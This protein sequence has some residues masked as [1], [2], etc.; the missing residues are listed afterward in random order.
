MLK[1]KK[2]AGEKA[3]EG[4]NVKEGEERG[5]QTEPLPPDISRS[6][7]VQSSIQKML[8]E[9]ERV[10]E[11][12]Q[13]REEDVPKRTNT[14]ASFGLLD[15][16]RQD[17][18]SSSVSLP[19]PIP[20]HGGSLTDPKKPQE[21]GEREAKTKT[22]RA[23]LN[24]FAEAS[25]WG[26]GGSEEE[27]KAKGGG[28]ASLPVQGKEEER[29]TEGFLTPTSIE[30]LRKAAHAAVGKSESPGL[31]FKGA[32]A[33]GSLMSG[34]SVR[35][36]VRT[37]TQSPPIEVFAKFETK[38]AKGGM[39]AA[40]TAKN[41]LPIQPSPAQCEMRNASARSSAFWD[42]SIQGTA[43]PPRGRAGSIQRVAQGPSPLSHEGPSTVPRHDLSGVPWHAPGLAGVPRHCVPSPFAGVEQAERQTG[44]MRGA[45]VPS[46]VSEASFRV[47]QRHA[48]G[49][50]V[51]GGGSV[52]GGAGAGTGT[53][54]CRPDSP[55][56]TVRS[57]MVQTS[58]GSSAWGGRWGGYGG[59]VVPGPFASSLG[60]GGMGGSVSR[61]VG[62][63]LG[64]PL[65]TRQAEEGER[66]GGLGRTGLFADPDKSR[67][68][69]RE[70]RGEGRRE[71]AAGDVD[72]SPSASS[73][74]VRADCPTHSHSRVQR[75]QDCSSSSLSS[76]RANEKRGKT[77]R[78][79][80]IEEETFDGEETETETGSS[81]GPGRRS[82][83]RSRLSGDGRET[84]RDILMEENLP[85]P[86]TQPLPSR[87]SRDGTGAF[88]SVSS[89]Q[90]PPTVKA[91][92]R[93]RHAPSV[94]GGAHSP[95]RTVSV[96]VD[97]DT[98]LLKGI[99]SHAGARLVPRREGGSSIAAAA[100]ASTAAP[101]SER[102]PARGSAE[103][104][105]P[106]FDAG[107]GSF[108]GGARLFL[109]EAGERGREGHVGGPR[110]APVGR[111]SPARTEGP[112]TTSRTGRTSGVRPFSRPGERGQYLPTE[113]IPRTVRAVPNANT[114]PF[115]SSE[116]GMQR[117]RR[118]A[119][120]QNGPAYT[121]FPPFP[122]RSCL[123]TD[124]AQPQNSLPHQSVGMFQKQQE[125]TK[126]NSA[127]AT[128]DWWL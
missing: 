86:L 71:T 69:I 82:F 90:Q 115:A 70:V 76:H 80:T 65:E 7:D 84:K 12:A 93:G 107:G 13:R 3:T 5:E 121:D 79:T 27:S 54:S 100:A 11:E 1:E 26:G 75:Q 114:N 51:I 58:G 18:S 30:E 66:A 85:H 15:P 33:P 73:S 24:P 81:S 109:H 83:E 42:R 35:G 52:R 14:K 64:S 4:Q 29:S 61:G 101:F 23:S 20:V 128:S 9:E 21:A 91:N 41:F 49:G 122:S 53:E 40:Q 104:F 39:E 112:P 95:A 32:A 28:S 97:R 8:A 60:V 118:Q 99:P 19:I 25:L 102:E 44:G 89:S 94:S 124:M 117:S 38:T 57:E 116:E 78:P 10:T 87:Y 120:E 108:G 106:S 111:I 22:S 47:N 103:S 125:G 55:A 45:G 126:P 98:L 127:G 48:V 34:A 74:R 110:V 119:D 59:G 72:V 105:I 67:M 56:V 2:H 6:E 31:P 17:P 43:A 68:F 77:Y 92:G 36:G 123:K 46:G 62:F 113:S 50:A 63:S 37:V 96:S 88:S 16:S